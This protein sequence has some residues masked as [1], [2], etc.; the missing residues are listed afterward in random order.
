MLLS[1]VKRLRQESNLVLDLR[2]VV[3]DPP[4]PRDKGCALERRFER[5]ER[6]KISRETSFRLYQVRLTIHV[7][8][9]HHPPP[10]THPV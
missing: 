2:R 8:S 3:C 4:H 9:T 6:R 10:T 7:H 5:G 1:I